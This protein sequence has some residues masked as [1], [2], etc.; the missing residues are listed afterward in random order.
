MSVDDNDF[1]NQSDSIVPSGNP[2]STLHVDD[3]ERLALDLANDI[4]YAMRPEC[5]TTVAS[6]L[7]FARLEHTSNVEKNLQPNQCN[8]V[9]RKSVV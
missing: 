8:L 7:R 5:Q 2:I 3:F 6:T 1:F 9:D 4:N